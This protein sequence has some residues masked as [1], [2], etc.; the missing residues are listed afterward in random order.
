MLPVVVAAV[1]FGHRLGQA[2]FDDPGE[3]MHAEIARELARSG[4]PFALTLSGVRYV[5]KPPLLYALIALT[6]R[7]GGESELT[8][9]LV[10]AVAAVAGVAATAWLGTRLLGT[11]GGIVAGLALLTSVGFFA[12]G[13]YVRPDSLFV[14][15]LAWGFA[16]VLI[17]LADERRRLV[18]C[19]VLAFGVAALAKD[20]L[21]L[22]APLGV[23]A[24]AMTLAG[25]ARPLG[26]WL[27]WWSLTGAL[28]MAFGWWVVQE[29]RTPGYVWYTVVDNHVRNVA[30]TRL[31]PDE[32]VPLTA[33][34]F[35]AVAAFGAGPWMVAAIAS[36]VGLARRRAWRE[37][38]ELPWIM[39]ALWALGVFVATAISPFRLP[40]YGLPAY[41]ALALLAARAWCHW[42]G[43]G[44]LVTHASG[45]A[46]LAA[47][48]ALAWRSDGEVFM[49][50]VMETTD[51]A[52]RKTAAVDQA[53]PLPP[54]E[55]FQ[56]L[57]G[58][59]AA[60]FASGALLSAAVTTRRR[61][62]ARAGAVPIVV[63]MLALMPSVAAALS[64]VA[65]HRAVRSLGAEIARRAGDRDVVAH[66]GPL[67]NSGA[68]EWYSTRRP[69]II[70][71][72]RSVL[73][74][75]A[76]RPGESAP[77]W[78]AETTRAHWKSPTRV[79]AV[80]TRDPAHSLVARLPGARIV[81]TAGGRW[82]YLSPGP[83]GTS[84]ASTVAKP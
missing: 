45:L 52:S 41:P 43:R 29:I 70:D 36:I 37:P 62:A 25:R 2:P 59:T 78:D 82:L 81:A 73:G 57:F 47:I 40:H 22:L 11:A 13:R 5:D 21:G 56:E 55:R 38:E 15:S 26:R 7:V 30:R 68:L 14:A 42:R 54:W 75:A 84:S 46:L 80:T 58:P 3:G 9:R 19:G 27:P 31:F 28:L 4:D 48:C 23:V 8:A 6:F 1:L 65:T 20:P 51:V 24:L 64:L 60:V 39:L 33:L 12:Y 16:L 18:G 10:P 69:V 61:L 76:S 44:L 66:E 74:F 67:E 34:Q 79:W 17:G 49:T 53:S 71:G 35:L 50:R 32:D 63:T 72:R 83:D 77:F